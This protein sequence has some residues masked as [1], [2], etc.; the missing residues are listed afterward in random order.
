VNRTLIAAALIVAVTGTLRAAPP[1][2]TREQRDARMQW[3][4]EARFGMFIHWGIYSVPAGEWEGRSD[5]GE[6]IME[7]AKVPASRYERFAGQ[8]NPVKFDARAWVRAAKDA[9]MKYIVITS[10]HHDGFCMFDTK[11][12]EYNIMHAPFARDPMKELA[13]ACKEEG[14]KFCFYHSIMDW[15]HPLYAPRRPWNDTAAGEPDMDKY[16]QYMKAELKE[17][18]SNYGPIGIL[19]FD[20]QWEKTWNAQRGRDLY[21]FT[22]SLQPGIIVNNR[23]GGGVGDYQTPEQE[24]P[25]TGLPGGEPWETCMTMNDHWG[26][27]KADK[28]FKS[29]KQLIQM[30]VDIASKGG[31][32]LLNVGPSSEGLIPQESLDRMREIGRWT[33]VNG[34]AIYGT[35]ASPFKRLAWGRATQ[36]SGKLYLHVFDWPTDGKLI[37]PATN[38]AKHAYVLSEPSKALRTEQ[39]EAGITLSQLPASSPDPNATV[40][41]LEIDGPPNVIPPPAPRQA[42]DG[43]ITLGADDA[44]LTGGARVETIG[45]QPN[46]GYWTNKDATASWPVQIDKPGSFD[47]ELTYACKPESA[48][49]E[50]VVLLGERVALKAKVGATKGW[51][52]FVTRKI[53]MVMIDKPGLVTLTIKAMTP[54]PEGVMNLRSVRLTPAK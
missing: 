39:S 6:W 30:L 15:H 16:V 50:Y 14:L 32:Y 13:E 7:S 46:I 24:I 20:G 42:R 49:T 36:R 2:E 48:G 37:V 35:S 40:I 10:K 53:G 43:T 8:F 29:T 31:N 28:N 34:E 17:L 52:D 3:F 22:R 4:R 45:N 12:T 47:V 54:P 11:Q 1:T 41:V 21:D 18:T 27:N 51:D 38:S 25:A 44:D 9:G 5:Y 19:W 26:Y 23:A 33:K